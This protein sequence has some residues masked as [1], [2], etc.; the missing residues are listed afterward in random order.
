MDLP[1]KVKSPQ[2][3]WKWAFWR[4]W[5]AGF[6]PLFAVLGGGIGFALWSVNTPDAPLALPRVTAF[7]V[8]YGAGALLILC[9]LL[10]VLLL[11]VNSYQWRGFAQVLQQATQAVRT[12]DALRGPYYWPKTR[13]AELRALQ[14]A[15]EAAAS[16]LDA[17]DAEQR[18]ELEAVSEPAVRLKPVEGSTPPPPIILQPERNAPIE[19]RASVVE[20]DA[21]NALLAPPPAFL[22]AMDSLRKQLSDA[23][24][25]LAAAQAERVHPAAEAE[26]ETALAERLVSA[27]RG[28]N[29]ETGVAG[30]LGAALAVSESRLYTAGSDFTVLRD[31]SG[32]EKG[33]LLPAELA[34]PGHPLLFL[35]IERARALWVGHAQE[36]PRCARLFAEQSLPGPLSLVAL[37]LPDNGQV[38]IGVRAQGAQGWRAAEQIFAEAVVHSQAAKPAPAAEPAPQPETPAQ[39]AAAQSAHALWAQPN[40]PKNPDLPI[41]RDM[42]DSAPAGVFTLTRDGRFTYAN[43]QA[44]RLFGAG[45]GTV[46]LGNPLVA[47]VAAGEEDNVRAAIQR[48]LDGAAVD[49]SDVA[50]RQAAGAPALL[51][52]FLSP[53]QDENGEPTG[54]AG[55]ALNVTALRAR[56]LGLARQEAVYRGIVEGAPQLL[57]SVDAIGCITFV[58]GVSREI[59]GYAPEELLGRPITMLC[60][61]AQARTDLERLA[62]LLGGKPCTGYRTVHRH[63]DGSAVPLTVVAA[64]QLDANGRVT[65]AVG[66]A[67]AMDGDGE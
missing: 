40:L 5:L 34:R 17:R 52:L 49:E 59:Y 25:A 65:Q 60:D 6:F 31:V 16:G 39:P 37:L 35:G 66:L 67:I 42:V 15:V 41:F 53:L 32:V 36:D 30:V 22:A 14:S 58:N 45:G 63:K 46:L 48:V 64:R 19:V 29:A 9:A 2:T 11:A 47:R 62:L 50:F 7:E 28:M 27:L 8:Y 3:L 61:E 38:W 10:S 4:T 23:K 43:P 12:L 55:C 1:S 56:E 44:E 13:I 20:P 33:G 24:A 26:A 57:W 51:R 21:T 18:G 54:I